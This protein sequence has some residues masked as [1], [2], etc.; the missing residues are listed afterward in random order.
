MPEW[1][2]DGFDHVPTPYDGRLLIKFTC[3]KCGASD[4]VSRLDDSL[5]KWESSHK[6]NSEEHAA[7]D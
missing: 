1:H 6:C 3:K 2:N 5:L 7:A 4:L